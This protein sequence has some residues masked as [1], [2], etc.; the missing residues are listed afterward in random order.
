MDLSPGLGSFYV[1]KLPKNETENGLSQGV[2][3]VWDNN[4]KIGKAMVLNFKNGKIDTSMYATSEAQRANQ[5]K[6][7]IDMYGNRPNDNIMSR[8]VVSMANEKWINEEQF[9]M[10]KQGAGDDYNAISY[11]KSLDE[12][13]KE[14]LLKS[15]EAKS[16]SNSNSDGNTNSNSKSNTN[17]NSKFNGNSNSK[18]NANSNSNSNANS[19]SNSNPNNPVS[20]VSS[21]SSYS[22][23]VGT[24]GD[25]ATNAPA[26]DESAQDAKANSKNSPS[27][28]KSYEVSKSIPAKSADSNSLIYA[29]IGVLAI[30]V[31]LGLGYMKRK[32]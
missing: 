3:I 17:A 21:S 23:S 16:N 19:N 12:V 29:L 27:N 20:Q 31:V 25:V 6:G 32:N 9:N 8:P 24:S 2:L 10:L 15:I 5:I 28:S 18:S 4:L 14:E 13:T 1:Q 22:G 11:L 7:F 30:G 26:N